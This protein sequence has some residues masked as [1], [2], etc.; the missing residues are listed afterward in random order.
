MS[1]IYLCIQQI[2]RV[3]VKTEVNGS[4]NIVMFTHMA[5]NKFTKKFVILG[6]N[7]THGKVGMTVIKDKSILNDKSI[8]INYKHKSLVYE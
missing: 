2:D 1:N 5:W 8:K 3:T 6:K 7:L 4:V